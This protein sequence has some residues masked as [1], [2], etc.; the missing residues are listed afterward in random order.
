MA[1]VRRKRRG[2]FLGTGVMVTTP[3]V[4]GVSSA[5]SSS[6]SRLFN[7]T[8]TSIQYVNTLVSSLVHLLEA[9]AEIGRVGVC[10]TTRLEK[11]Q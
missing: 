7:R 8:Q 10:V 4:G 6:P 2:P 9:V 5:S 11:E 1:L 3:T